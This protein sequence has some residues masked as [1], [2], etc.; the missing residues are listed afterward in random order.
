MFQHS[1]ITTEYRKE[2]DQMEKFEDFKSV[3]NDER[4]NS[5]IP[6]DEQET[7]ISFQRGGDLLDVWT[8]D[9]TIMTKLDKLCKEAPENYKCIEVVKLMFNKGLAN[10]RYK[11]SDK[12]LLSLRPRRMKRELTD[13]Q[14][15]VLSET[16][17]ARRA[18]GEL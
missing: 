11:C 12:G 5:G 17:K 6:L 14:R 7:V 8:T 1:T 9:T 4:L 18:S 10:K 2:G 13:E 3:P 15:A 16:M